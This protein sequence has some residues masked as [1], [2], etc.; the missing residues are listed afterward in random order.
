MYVVNRI[1][2][3]IKTLQHFPERCGYPMELLQQNNKNYRETYFG[4]YRI[5]YEI[6]NGTVYVVAVADGR[7]DMAAFLAE[8]LG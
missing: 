3:T 1:H 2:D 7:R 6:K 4:P 8:R 5:F